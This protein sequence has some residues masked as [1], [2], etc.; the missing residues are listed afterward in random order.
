[1]GKKQKK[2]GDREKDGFGG[3]GGWGVMARE[4]G[5]ETEIEERWGRQTDIKMRKGDGEETE[6][7][8]G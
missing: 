3:S 4:G 8:G 6:E 7:E 1:M 5:R 2:K